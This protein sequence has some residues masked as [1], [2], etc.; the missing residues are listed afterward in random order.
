MDSAKLNFP[1]ACASLC[2]LMADQTAALLR[3]LP[4]IDY[5]LK[6]AR[7]EA[8]MTRYNREY[9]MQQCRAVLD[10]MRFE[11]RQNQGGAVDVGEATILDRLEER[12]RV[13]SR[14]GHIRV[15]NATGTILHTNLGRALLSQAA[16]EA[17]VEVA[18]HPIN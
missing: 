18:D 6:H 4:S 2:F 5:L 13:D 1:V 7:C 17:M 9:V 3:E 10:R 8:L 15:V 11:I 16:I 14:P 12:I